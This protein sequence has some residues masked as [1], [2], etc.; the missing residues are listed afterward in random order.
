M[1]GIV[2]YYMVNFFMKLIALSLLVVSASVFSSGPAY[3]EC[4]KTIKRYFVGTSEVDQNTA[5]LW[6]TFAEGGSASMSSNSRAF[7]G[8]L[9]TSITAFVTQKKVNVRYYDPA[10][11]CSLHNGDL[12][13]IWLNN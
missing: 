4:E 8:V 2:R 10:S 1:V 5:H 7:Q 12:V 11:D 9:A 13:G 6:V 3:K